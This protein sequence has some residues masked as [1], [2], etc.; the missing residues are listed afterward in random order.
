MVALIKLLN[1]NFYCIQSHVSNVKRSGG[2]PCV[3][4]LP[5]PPVPVQPSVCIYKPM[6]RT[7]PLLLLH[8][9][10]GIWYTHFC[11]FLT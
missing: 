8:R 11:P 9:N 1:F 3:W 2:P 10:G 4:S 6:Q 5:S 7:V